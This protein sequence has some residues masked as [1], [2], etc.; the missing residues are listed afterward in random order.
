[1]T[2][3]VRSLGLHKGR[4]PLDISDDDIQDVKF[5]KELPPPVDGVFF[6]TP[7]RDVSGFS[8]IDADISD[9]SYETFYL[10]EEAK[11]LWQAID[12]LPHTQ[13]QS[14]YPRI[15]WHRKVDRCLEK[16]T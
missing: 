13:T 14:R 6:K 4:T 8:T 10:R 12:E 15:T 5:L 7:N 9:K 1:M 3:R 11:T 2:S 16:G